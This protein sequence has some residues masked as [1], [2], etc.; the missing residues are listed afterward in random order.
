MPRIDLLLRPGSH[1]GALLVEVLLDG[2][3]ALVRVVH[4]L[5]ASAQRLA[6][7][8]TTAEARCGEGVAVEAAAVGGASKAA[9]RAASE[10]AGE[11]TGSTAEAASAGETSSSTGASEAAVAHAVARIAT[12]AAEA[13]SA[14]ET[15][16][17][18]VRKSSSAKVQI[19]RFLHRALV[20]YNPL[21]A[22]FGC[23]PFCP[24]EPALKCD[25][26]FGC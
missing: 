24:S 22:I 4:G 19:I 7:E 9:S 13:W 6:R 23:I 14:A 21:E 25:S 8:A 15:A 17:R 18:C 5:E 16:A 2:L 1:N 11:T 26:R 10:A 3:Q 12:A 20:T